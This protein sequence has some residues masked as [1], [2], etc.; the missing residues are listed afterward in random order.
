M[1]TQPETNPHP[2]YSAAHAD[3]ERERRRQEFETERAAELERHWDRE[4]ALRRHAYTSAGGDG[5]AFDADW[6]KL[7]ERL[8]AEEAVESQRTRDAT[9]EARLRQVARNF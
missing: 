3:W 9:R 1:T 7:R 4:K 6:P 5:A 2:E 8:I